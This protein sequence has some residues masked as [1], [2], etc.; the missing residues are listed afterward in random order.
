MTPNVL[1]LLTALTLTAPAWGAEMK[2]AHGGR[3]ADA[4]EYH[5][6]MVTTSEV[7]DVYLA[8][9][10]NKAVP[11]MGHKGV[12]IMVVDGK[13]QRIVLKPSG[14]AKLSGKA[15]GALPKAPK[16]VI[17]ITLPKGKTVQARYN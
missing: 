7:I 3:M 13:S 11:A 9:H 5:V 10:D 16:G 12:A 4:G 8:D 17:Q 14:D 6:E 1:A 2:S 15:A